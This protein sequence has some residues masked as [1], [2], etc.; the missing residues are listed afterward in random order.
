M[1]LGKLFLGL[2]LLTN[3]LGFAQGDTDPALE[4]KRMKLF[5]GKRLDI[6]DFKGAA[7]FY[8]KAEGMCSDYDSDDYNKRLIPTLKN[9]VQ[10][11]QDPTAKAA[12][13][14][15]ILAVF[16]RT[17]K[18]NFYDVSN[19]LYRAAML[20]Q[21]TKADRKKADELFNR[22]MAAQK[23]LVHESYVTLY[24]Y[25]LYAMF[26]ESK[27]AERAGVK[28]LM[29]TKYF[30]LT[31]LV[32]RAKMSGATQ[33]ALNQYFNAVVQKCEDILPELGGFL[34]NLPQDKE[35]KK[36]TVKNFLTLL[37]SKGCN[38][39]K[40][41]EILIDTLIQMDP[42]DCDAIYGKA[43]RLESKKKY[44]EASAAY[45]DAKNCSKDANLIADCD[46]ALLRITF[47]SGNC[48][49]TYSMAMNYSGKY[50][51]EALKMAAQ[52]VA[53]NSANC[54]ASTFERKCAYYYAVTLLERAR[55]AGADV[56][57]LI[58]S[59]RANYPTTAEMFEVGK[60]RGQSQFIS[61]YGGITVTLE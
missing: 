59:Y 58:G 32:G 11:E 1:K 30:E 42:T 48:G 44:S 4:C 56:G 16:E 15:T 46:Y 18:K 25:N 27:D 3:T 2:V 33:D 13:T 39:S 40:E 8:L 52:C 6:N 26:A 17:E 36:K 47:N 20:A 61:C 37:E 22:G 51:G 12:Y 5:A 28:K 21:H 9:V 35:A 38:E 41:Y 24:Y 55:A 7:S 31:D 54:G 43:V 57:G 60:S 34:S 10:E 14:D 23:D 53:R 29:I 50:K 49:A 45:K 19:D